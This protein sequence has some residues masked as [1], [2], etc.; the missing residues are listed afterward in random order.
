MEA[1]TGQQNHLG[2]SLLF[3]QF[4][5]NKDTGYSV[6]SGGFIRKTTNGGENW[7]VQNS[8][9]GNNL[10]SVHF[11]NSDTGWAVGQY[12]TIRKTTDGGASWFSQ[13]IESMS[14]F[15]QQIESI[16]WYYAVYFI[17]GNNGFIGEGPNLGRLYRTTDGGSTW[18]TVNESITYSIRDIFFVNNLTGWAVG[19]A[20]LNQTISKTTD[21]GLSWF[22]QPTEIS[23]SPISVYFIDSNHGWLCS[24]VGRIFSTID[25][26]VSWQSQDTPTDV[27][28][29]EIYFTDISTGWSVGEQ[30]IILKTLTGGTIPVELTSFTG[31]AQHNYVSLNWQTATETNNSGF[32]IERK[33]VGS[34]QSSVGNQ[35]WNQ[36]AFVPGFGTTT[37]PKSYSFIDENLSSGKYQYRLKQIDFDGSFEYSN[38]VE[39]EVSTPVKFALEQNY[40]NPFNPSTVISYSLPQK[41]FV[42][43]K[44]IDI[45]GREVATLVNEVKPAG[46]FEVEFDASSLASGVYVY[47][48]KAG[49][50]TTSKKMLLTK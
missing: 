26:G 17:D 21:G 36:I 6:G 23:I 5:V 20:D 30:G 11:I 29:N 34:P 44:V 2:N 45:L 25:G 49:S 46:K 19:F 40:P 50:F 14:L 35:D 43:I 8:G 47:Q 15:G 18:N 22:N 39:V 41:E 9:T 32:K 16:S 13:Q 31:T 4:F 37:E 33:Q 10:L 3:I 42:S 27:T 38:T 7:G 24:T 28:L 1:L 12:N 48:I